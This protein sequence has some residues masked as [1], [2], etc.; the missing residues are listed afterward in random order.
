MNIKDKEDSGNHTIAF[1]PYVKIGKGSGVSKQKQ[2][3]SRLAR[4]ACT[5]KEIDILL[6]SVTNTGLQ[7]GELM[8]AKQW[9][10]IKSRWL[11]I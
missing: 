1:F 2:N 3:L 6:I 10:V 4:E 11:R 7:N 9:Q 8:V 5:K